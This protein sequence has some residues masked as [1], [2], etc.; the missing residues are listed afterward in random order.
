[1]AVRNRGAHAVIEGC[2]DH[3]CEYMTGGRVVILG[4]TGRNFAAGMSG[5][6]AYIWDPA[7]EFL[8]RCNLGTVEL[9]KVVAAGDKSELHALVQAHHK[10]TKSAV[11]ARLLADW[12]SSLQQFVKVM[13]VDYKRVLAERKLHD[14]EQESVVHVGK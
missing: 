10:Y 11:A 8:T 14:E 13:P 1:F 2:G 9:E 3:G 6:I 5:G 12:P 4:Q 7:N